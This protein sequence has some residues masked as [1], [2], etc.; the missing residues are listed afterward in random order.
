M[1]WRLARSLE[2]LRDEINAAAPTRSKASDGTVGDTSH[3]ARASDHNPNSAGVVRAMDVTDDAPTFSAD[4]LARTVADLLGTHPALGSGAYVIWTR[5]IISA[6]RRGEGWRPYSGSNPHNHHVHI[7]VATSAAG[8]DSTAPWLEEPDDMFTD[9]DR[10]VITDNA[11][12]LAALTK[13]F[14]R[15]ADNSWRREA[16]LAKA[17]KEQGVDVDKILAA[18]EQ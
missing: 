3:S 5:R 1:S 4:D 16:A 17:L 11:R 7:S 18:V 13:R 2:T 6:D 15:F 10:K 8:Y 14:D 12:D 9:D